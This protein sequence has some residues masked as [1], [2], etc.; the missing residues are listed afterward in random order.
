[1]D[2]TP[3][4]GKYSLEMMW[5][6]MKADSDKLEDHCRIHKI[7]I[8]KI[9]ED[10]TEI[11]QSLAELSQSVSL[12]TQKIECK[13]DVQPP[14]GFLGSWKTAAAGAIVLI[15]GIVEGLQYVKKL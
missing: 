7:D 12:L 3:G 10:T 2:N 5:D 1:M 14:Q 15:A 6:V 8:D 11:K 4:I 13:Q 9:H